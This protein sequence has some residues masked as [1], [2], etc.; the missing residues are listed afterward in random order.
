MADEYLN[1]EQLYSVLSVYFSPE[2]LSNLKQPREG[3]PAV[4][5]ITQPNS[6]HVYTLSYREGVGKFHLGLHVKGNSSRFL[7]RGFVSQE[8]LET[9]YR[10]YQRSR[11]RIITRR[12]F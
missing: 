7:L 6:P 3:L 8:K 12:G 1:L 11:A 10:I 4:I 2:H 5:S 9:Q